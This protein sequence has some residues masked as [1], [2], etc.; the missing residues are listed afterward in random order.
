MTVEVVS[1]RRFLAA[2]AAS[3]LAGVAARPL[4]REARPRRLVIGLGPA[5]ERVVGRLQREGFPGTYRIFRWPEGVIT[6]RSSVPALDG[7]GAAVDRSEAQ[8][9]SGE[10]GPALRA[11]VAKRLAGLPD[12]GARIVVVELGGYAEFMLAPAL[13]EVLGGQRVYVV[14]STPCLHE[15]RKR[16]RTAQDTL[17]Q[18]SATAALHRIDNQD[19]LAGLGWGTPFRE[20]LAASDAMMAETVCTAA[21]FPALGDVCTGFEL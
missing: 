12:A 15:G 16:R 10:T 19:V 5:G 17:S 13:V 9:W 8:G 18:L 7:S 2:A 11:A 3:A 21:G 6:P 14:C 4:G 20:L 1:R